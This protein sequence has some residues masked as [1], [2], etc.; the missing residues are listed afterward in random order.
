MAFQTT[1]NSSLAAGV[2]GELAADGPTRANPY[3]LNSDDASYNVFGRAFTVVSEGVAKAGGTGAFAGLMAF[4]K[5]NVSAGTSAGGTLA[6]TLTLRNG[7]VA[8]LL[9][10]GEMFIAVPAACAIGDEILYDT[11]TGALSTQTAGDTPGAG[12]AKVPNAV[13]AKY[14]PAAA[15]LAIARLT[16]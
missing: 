6:P 8:S 11:T 14:T 1:I 13:I 7:E 10:M 15:G 3:I 12:K 16:N 4:P 2:V 5:E 9:R